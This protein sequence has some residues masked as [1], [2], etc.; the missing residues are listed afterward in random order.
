MK[1]VFIG[2]RGVGKSDLLKRHQN[3]FPQTAHFDLDFEI[4]KKANSTISEIFKS[5]GETFFRKIE[6]ETFQQIIQN[7]KNYVISLGAGFD[8][9]KLPIEIESIFV[10]RMTDRDGRIFLNRPRLNLNRSPL[11]EFQER[12]FERQKNY[13]N[14]ATW[15]YHLP[16]GLE[17]SN[18]LEEKILK[19]SFQITDAYYTLTKN[20]L[21]GVDSLIKNFM[22]LELRTDLFS[23]D[24]ISN[25]LRAYPNTKWLVSVRT[26][27]PI[28][29]PLLDIDIQFDYKKAQIV[30]SHANNIQKAIQQL[31]QVDKNKYL[32]L[33]PV[34]EKFEDLISGYRW[35]Q[36]DPQKRS[37]LPRSESGKWNWYR[38]ISKYIQK[39]N[40]VRNF[41]DI[42]DQPSLY[43]WLLLPQEKP[44]NWGAVLGQPVHHSRS[45][46]AHQNFC[47][48][49]SR[50]EIDSLEF[51]IALKFL[52]ELGLSVAAV[53]SPL[54]EKAFQ[55]STH[56]TSEA[57]LFQSA[58][59]LAFHQNKIYAHNTDLF[60]FQKLVSEIKAMESVAVWG[61][62]GTLNMI[63]SVLPQAHYYSSQTG[64][65]RDSNKKELSQYDYLI[66]AAPRSEKT[67]FPSENFSFKTVI[68]LNYTENSMGLE[69]ASKQHIPYFSGIEMFTVQASEQQKFW[70]KSIAAM[71]K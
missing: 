36:Q 53:T 21:K 32:K 28:E 24:E 25:L 56:Q 57:K 23:K 40:F 14:S 39:I 2:H 48:M 11:D 67:R 68:D 19:K 61:G 38:Q 33:S 3:Y 34:V 71:N 31:S 22:H 62:G 65:L 51:E 15:I 10:S 59:T 41:T 35:Q 4:E 8:L 58:N 45:P 5:E 13:L 30:S 17:A 50:V 18:A 12:Y 26:H 55:I 46:V 37:F 47:Q 29:A 42:Q 63:K 16:E 60:G 27:E 64:K 54:K 1:R 70:A 52:I 69:F 9:T 44:K 49:F 66:W 43:E 20:D 7:H 6:K